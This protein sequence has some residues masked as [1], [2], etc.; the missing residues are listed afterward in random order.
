MH[1]ALPKRRIS[2]SIFSTIEMGHPERKRAAA[3]IIGDEILSGKTQ[4]T[5]TKTLAQFL[6]SNGV[7]LEKTET[8]RDDIEIISERVRY[9]SSS[10]DLVFTSGGIGPTLDDLTYES[11]AVAFDRSLKLHDET[12]L[13]MRKLSPDM[14]LN[15]ARKRMAM[16]PDQCVVFWTDGLWVPLARVQNVY[17]L[18]GIPKLFAK[19]IESIPRTELGS[20]APR[21]KRVVL[22][23]VAEGDL[24]DALLRV[25]ED[26]PSVALGSYP[27]TTREARELY[28]TMVTVEGELEEDVVSAANRIRKAV[29]GV[30]KM[31]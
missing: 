7:T 1:H 19:M 26:V 6:V 29:D 15:M 25:K 11:V 13:R 22:C 18:P 24:A 4:D 17:I 28:T 12:L 14:E 10:H 16:L 23:E 3:L 5:N 9:L 2:K 27:A 8:I 20:Y 21:A 31:G 30:V